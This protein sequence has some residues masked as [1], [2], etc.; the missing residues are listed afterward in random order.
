VSG[1]ATRDRRR[2]AFLRAFCAAIPLHE[3]G[4]FQTKGGCACSS[5]VSS[6]TSV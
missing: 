6:T 4:A 5:S 3:L 1:C 2:V